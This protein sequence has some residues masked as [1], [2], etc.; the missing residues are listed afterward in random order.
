MVGSRIEASSATSAATIVFFFLSFAAPLPGSETVAPELPSLGVII[1]VLEPTGVVVA[2]PAA[3]VTR[4]VAPPPETLGRTPSAFG[5]LEY[6]WDPN[7]PGGVPGFSSSPKHE[8]HVA[9]ASD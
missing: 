3:E 8:L 1:G 5:F 7:A 9:N 4:V 6:D 2:A